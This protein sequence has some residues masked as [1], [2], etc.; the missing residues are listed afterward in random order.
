MSDWQVCCSPESP[1]S[2]FLQLYFLT[3][4]QLGPLQL[5]TAAGTWWRTAWWALHQLPQYPWEDPIQLHISMCLQDHLNHWP[6]PL[7]LWELNFAFH[8]CL[9]ALGAGYLKSNY[10]CYETLR[11]R[12]C[13]CNIQWHKPLCFRCFTYKS[14]DQSWE[15]SCQGKNS[16][17]APDW[18]PNILC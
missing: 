3:S 7:W 15:E 6:V 14:K 5:G 10:F 4:S 12:R 1:S 17:G 9:L 2:P 8:P 13:W 11:Q 16:I 18:Y